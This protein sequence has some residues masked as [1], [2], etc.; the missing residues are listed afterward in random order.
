M[1][2][3]KDK[4]ILI[5]KLL[6]KYTPKNIFYFSGQ[7]SLTKS[8]KLKKVTND[9]NYIGA[10]KILEIL[11]KYE[12]KTNFYKANSGYIFEP[13]KG[14]VNI[15][16]KISKNKNPYIQSQ[17]KA[18]KEVKKFRKKGVN[19]S[20]IFFLQV[21]SPLRNNDFFIKKI[22]THAKLK[23]IL[24]L[25]ILIRYEIIPGL[26]KLLKAFI[27]LQKLNLEI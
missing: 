16:S 9:S 1:Q 17:I 4:L 15:K 24:L 12:L 19:C 2:V 10:K 11:H 26:Q 7:S 23:K 14:L 22:C 3:L 25:V 13:N 20:S 18:H 21:E 6:K 27:I 8:I 5:L